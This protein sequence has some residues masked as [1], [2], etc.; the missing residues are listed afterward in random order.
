MKKTF[1]S[2]IICHLLFGTAPGK[3]LRVDLSADLIGNDVKSRIFQAEL[4]LSEG[5][6][7]E[8][9]TG[10]YT[11]GLYFKGIES[12]QYDFEANLYGLAP[13]YNISEY[14]FN[15]KPREKMLIPSLP[16]KEGSNINFIITLIDDTSTIALT[17][18]S[19]K[20][21]SLWGFS[22]TIHYRT[23]WVKGSLIDFKWNT[24]MSYL[25][26]TYNKYRES[27][28]LSEFERIDMYIHPEPTD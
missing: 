28:R 26:F 14:D 8:I 13:E 23:R 20:D 10:A 25:E 5:E 4:L 18:Y 9:F 6:G 16:V 27:Y 11:V 3:T 22:E 17:Q 21:T 19:L 24:V 1:L 2:L 12:G 7:H 15:L